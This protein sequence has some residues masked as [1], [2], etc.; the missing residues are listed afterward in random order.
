MQCV[1]PEIDSYSPVEG[2]NDD[3]LT[4]I[5]NLVSVTER[6]RIERV[7]KRWECIAKASWSKSKELQMNAQV[8]GLNIDLKDIDGLYVAEEI[9]RRCGRY[10]EKIIVVTIDYYMASLLVKYC[11][12]IQSIKCN[13]ISI[14]GIQILSDNYKNISKLN[15]LCELDDSFEE[16]LGNLFFNNKNLKF[17]KFP[18]Y[19]CSVDCLMKLPLDKIVTIKL[20]PNH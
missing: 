17:L 13:E 9:F 7:C 12:I 8:L 3:C 6:I 1:S 5:F 10:L 18:N 2:L 16:A 15:I 11:P 20:L 14:V 19:H 4:Y